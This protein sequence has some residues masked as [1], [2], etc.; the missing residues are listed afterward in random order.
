MNL[1]KRFLKKDEVN[2]SDEQALE[3]IAEL[4]EAF[5]NNDSILVHEEDSLFMEF[6][7]KKYIQQM[8]FKDN[9][10][11]VLMLILLAL[12]IVIC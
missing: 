6:L 2:F 11:I 10:R 7:L 1:K 4:Q 12:A 5:K 9:V 8:E 3:R